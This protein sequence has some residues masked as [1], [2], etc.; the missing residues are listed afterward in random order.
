MTEEFMASFAREGEAR[1]F[2]GLGEAD[3]LD[4]GID[5]RS[6]EIRDADTGQ[7]DNFHMYTVGQ[8]ALRHD[9]LSLFGSA[10]YFGRD[11]VYQ[12]RNYG[13]NYHVDIDTHSLAFKL[14]YWIPA[15]GIQSNNHDLSIKK[16][17]GFG[18]GS[19]KFIG[20]VTW[21]NR[22]FESKV[23]IA[24]SDIDIVKGKDNFPKNDADDKP[25]LIWDVKLKRIEKF[26]FG[27]HARV[28]DGIQT[29][30]GYSTRISKGHAYIFLQQD[31]D[32]SKGI[33]TSYGRFGFFPVRGLDLYFEQDQLETSL[34]SDIRRM[35]GFS[36]MIR[37]R[38]EYEGQGM[39][40]G[41]KRYLQTSLKLWM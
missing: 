2:F 30:L 6:M 35:L 25:E 8:L 11:R 28:Q 18:R 19:E 24:H 21:L 22:W 32:Q 17:N 12:T 13:V 1:E 31:S 38:F 7:R 34:N 36:W 37:P 39:Q 14:G 16:A 41:Q 3:F 33:L 23:M 29:L 40:W 20:Q 10:G 27:V 9:G 26:E 4:L 5:Y 15:I